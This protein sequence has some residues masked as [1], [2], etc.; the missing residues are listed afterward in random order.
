M[1]GGKFADAELG[2]FSK[3]YYSARF[4][5]LHE[6]LK[7]KLAT[8]GYRQKLYDRLKIAKKSKL[9]EEFVGS[10]LSVPSDYPPYVQ[11]WECL[12]ASSKLTIDN[13]ITADEAE[14]G[15]QGAEAYPSIKESVQL[16]TDEPDTTSVPAD[17]SSG[18]SC[19]SEVLD[20]LGELPP[21]VVAPSFASSSTCS[22]AEFLDVLGDLPES[23]VDDDETIGNV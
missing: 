11:P 2:N 19:R 3:Q 22:N 13:E 16:S 6:V 4:L 20:L 7:R 10:F 15:Q 23:M 5:R 1:S 17:A 8:A 12:E 21:S 18:G 14:A 9:R